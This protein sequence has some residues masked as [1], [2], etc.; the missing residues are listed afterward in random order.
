[1]LGGADAACWA[2][3]TERDVADGDGGVWPP[4]TITSLVTAVQRPE[5]AAD[6]RQ[7]DDP[8]GTGRRDVKGLFRPF[9]QGRSLQ[10]LQPWAILFVPLIFLPGDHCPCLQA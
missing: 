7:P 10:V 5:R 6:Q 4:C 1:V 9:Y 8:E 2:G 3:L